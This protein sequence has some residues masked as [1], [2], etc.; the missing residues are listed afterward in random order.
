VR[1]LT[2]EREAL[3]RAVERAVAT[4]PRARVISLFD[5]GYGTGR[6]T[7]EFIE[8][9]VADNG[10]SGRD[11]R[12]VAYDVSSVGLIKA[13]DILCSNGFMP[14]ASMRWD[15]NDTVGYIAGNVSRT[16]SD[17]TVT[18]VFIHGHESQ[19]PKVMRRLALKANGGNRYLVTTSWYSGIGHIPGDR[20]RRKHFR[21]LGK[22]TNRRGEMIISVSATGDLVELQPEFAE[23]LENGATDGFPINEPGDLVYE[24]ELGQSNYYHVFSTDLNDHIR[25]ITGWRQH[26][27]I[28]G[29]RYP[30]EEFVRKPEERTNYL[31]VLR[32]NHGKRN[33]VWS[34]A[35]Y[36]EFHTVAAFRSAR[37]AEGH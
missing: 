17:I 25:A 29:I 24:T 4:N 12:V 21:Q 8:S 23:R 2:A 30:D 5:F 3:T 9:Y 36:Q 37:N 15:P 10:S 32:A 28:E 1:V 6:V 14:D 16:I 33:R 34:A 27:W 31:R 26:W 22:L 18:F 19:P 20:L 35:D 13:Y 7:N 11:L